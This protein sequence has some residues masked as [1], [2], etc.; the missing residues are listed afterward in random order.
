MGKK[1]SK[2]HGATSCHQF[3]LDGYLPEA[4]INYLALLGWNDGT[5][6]DIYSRNELINAF[7][8]DRLI[9]SPSI[10]DIDKLRWINSQH[11]KRRSVE[12]LVDLVKEQIDILGFFQ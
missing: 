4:M 9:R 1:L 6:K 11:L 3:Q 5:N 10:F 2:R 8:I 7:S 12:D